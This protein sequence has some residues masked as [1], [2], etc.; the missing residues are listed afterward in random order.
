VSDYEQHLHCAF[1]D[2]SLLSPNAITAAS[3]LLSCDA[4]VTECSGRLL[5]L[6]LENQSLFDQAQQLCEQPSQPAAVPMYT[7]HHLSPVLPLP[8]AATRPLTQSTP[9]DIRCVCPTQLYCST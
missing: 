5:S 6:A 4:C 7:S 8:S 1:G 3:C 9:A 2:Y